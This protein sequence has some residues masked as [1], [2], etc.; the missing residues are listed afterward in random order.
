M[1]AASESLRSVSRRIP[2]GSWL[3]LW[4]A[5][6][7]VLTPGIASA[8]PDEDLFKKADEALNK[9]DFDTAITALTELTTKHTASTYL[10]QA[11]YKLGY[12]N[13]LKGNFLPA[14]K[15]LEPLTDP[16]FP[17]PGIQESSTLLLAQ[18]FGRAGEQEKEIKTKNDFF[19]RAIKAI[20]GF[21]LRFPRS[22]NLDAAYYSR[23]VAMMYRG[24]FDD[25][26]KAVDDYQQRFRTGQQ[27][28]DSEFLRASILAAKAAA[29]AKAG[30]KEEANTVRS[31]ARDK[32]IQLMQRPGVDV[33][34]SN[35]A[36]LRAAQLFMDSKQY[37]DAIMF[38]RLVRPKAD[39][40]V[41]Q[42]AKVKELNDGLAKMI[43]GN[44]R[45]GGINSPAVIRYRERMMQEQAKLEGIKKEQDYSVSAALGISVCYMG[46]DEWDESVIMCK[47]ML[48][49]LKGDA[50][51][52]DRK[53]ALDAIIRGLIG[54]QNPDLSLS[55]YDEFQKE[56]P[57]D[58]LAM[59]SSL[60]LAELFWSKE[61]PDDALKMADRVLAD[62]PNTESAEKVLVDK[63]SI[64]VGK[65]EPQKA[66]EVIQLYLK[67][68]PGDKGKH[69]AEVSHREAQV[70]RMIGEMQ[71]ALDGFKKVREKHPDAEF[72][73]EV[74]MEV[75][76]ALISLEKWDEAIAELTQFK[77]RFAT[78]RLMPSAL[79]Q[80]GEG[81]VGKMRQALTKA[82]QN[83]ATELLNSAVTTY[84]EIL[85][86]W[87]EDKDNAPMAMYRTG[88]A[89]FWIKNYEDMAKTFD[90]LAKKYP[91]SPLVSDAHFWVGYNFQQLRQWDEA[92][93]EFEIVTTKYP[94]AQVAPEASLRI[95]QCWT[96]KTLTV[97][98]SPGVLDGE[99]RK[100]W[101]ESAAKALACYEQTMAQYADA[102]ST[103]TAISE[104]L[105][106]QTIKLKSKV[107]DAAGV[108]TY[109][110]ALLAG[111]AGKN[112]ALKVKTL[113]AFGNLLY[114][115]GDPKRALPVFVRAVQEGP[116]IEVDASDYE[117]YAKTLV[118]NGQFDPAIA[119]YNK[120]AEV[121]MKNGDYPAWA[122][123][124]FGIGDAAFKKKDFN[125]TRKQFEM[126]TKVADDLKAKTRKPEQLTLEERA[127]VNC[128]R[129]AEAQ[130]GMAHILLAE[131]KFDQAIAKY[132]EFIEASRGI[133][134]TRARAV[135][136]LAYAL[137]ARAATKPGADNR[138]DLEAAFVNFA[139]AAEFYSVFDEI[140]PEALFR[141]GETANR[142][143][144]MVAQEP[145][146]PETAAAL[147]K[148]LKEWQAEV[149][150]N[151]DEFVKR[152]P[153]DPNAN[154]AKEALAKLPPPPKPGR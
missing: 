118:D 103:I 12:A 26:L 17:D 107:M 8:G 77:E 66:L 22:E 63:A 29:A 35:E 101:D 113:Y 94:T 140:A 117:A 52:E 108:D 121:A 139:Q 75:G 126:F 2:R 102:P 51:K 154:A 23:A 151:F 43:T 20:D 92:I 142:V 82:D 24:L 90:E 16:K 47:H 115:L 15:I 122:D 1:K 98:R 152:F 11:K 58:P 99:R 123:A 71:K 147:D 10:N 148:K 89:Y 54:G 86:R 150:R 132:K 41:S 116:N 9:A 40:L 128:K 87:P 127:L 129:L 45:T 120:M 149:R 57:K 136:G 135:L 76:A 59:D 97:G 111:P 65:N 34:V 119:T 44:I 137:L 46:Q 32:F 144:G 13:F 124:M 36:A 105:N 130:L 19:D 83:A 112:L 6:L 80:L 61:R 109:F 73:D 4:A 153:N 49:C 106:I 74:N 85:T 33:A 100:K 25:S 114:A 125:L 7:L 60:L 131:K 18:T 55:Y 72:T 141:A 14:I 30:Q 79:L 78:S 68:Y 70:Y 39:V 64:L 27:F 93:K 3:G 138:A 5:A 146:T 31:Q 69:T 95:G 53:R 134:V 91:A 110:N 104:I 56:F 81:Y 48:A 67:Q 88:M 84:K 28:Q 50:F 62:Y 133:N 42:E 143:A 38:F 145:S 96:A 37:D 21:I